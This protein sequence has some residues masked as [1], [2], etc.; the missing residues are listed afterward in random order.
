[1]TSYD[2][3]TI[4]VYEEVTAVLSLTVV[5]NTL[6][7]CCVYTM[8]TAKRA[9][10]VT[11]RDIRMLLWAYG[12]KQAPRMIPCRAGLTHFGQ[13]GQRGTAKFV[14]TALLSTV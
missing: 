1:M 7:K 12:G 10:T 6:V 14:N 5:S 8:F 4:A 13:V 3:F 11:T 9:S 2:C